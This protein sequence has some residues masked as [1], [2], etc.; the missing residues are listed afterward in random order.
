MVSHEITSKEDLKVRIFEE[1]K[2]DVVEE[3]ESRQDNIKIYYPYFEII[4]KLKAKQNTFE[5]DL[6]GVFI[7]LLSYLLYEGKLNNRRVEYN[8]IYQFI[9]YFILETY[10]AEYDEDTLKE[11]TNLILDEAQ[12]KGN[13]FSFTYY[14]IKDKKPKEKY[15]KYIE[16][17]ISEEGT[18]NYYITSQGI[19]FYLKTKE[20]PDAAQVTINLLLFRKQIKKGS[21]EYAYETVKRLNIEVRR[22]IEQKEAIIEG[23]MYGGREGIDNYYKYHEEVKSQ[24]DEEQELFM[25]VSTIVKNLYTEYL[26]K[27]NAQ[28][29][30]KK[31]NETIKTIRRIELELNKAIGAH[32]KLLEEASAMH[33]KYDDIINMKMKSA[34]SQKFGFEKEF[35]KLL[36]LIT[37]LVLQ[38]LYFCGM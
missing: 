8:D 25:D 23:L 37:H 1:V 21:F 13:N 35:E 31:E 12:N 38:V 4:R 15:L 3:L 30:E 26:Q 18:L 29:F 36:L 9:K 32:T 16:I 34:F 7:A 14:S 5:V 20:F 2:N 10:S 19:D 6:T 22:K 28:N 11:I 24:F 17:K 27:E 33:Q